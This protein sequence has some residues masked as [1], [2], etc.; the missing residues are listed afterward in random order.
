M[1]RP[2]LH[3]GLFSRSG[4]ALLLLASACSD[5][6]DRKVP[7]AQPLAACAP[8]SGCAGCSS[9]RE[10]CLCAGQSESHCEQS[11]GPSGAGASGGAAGSAGTSMAGS[12]GAG[13]AGASSGGANGG[14]PNGGGCSEWWPTPECSGGRSGGAAGSASGAGGQGGGSAGVVGAG[15]TAGSSNGG[16]GPTTSCGGIACQSSLPVGNVSL[17]AC[18]SNLGS[19]GFD[20][21]P[22]RRELP[23]DGCVALNQPGQSDPSCPTTPISG[24]DVTLPGCCKPN[25]TCGTNFTALAP[26]GCVDTNPFTG[27]PAS[28]CRPGGETD[29]G[30]G[31]AGTG[32]FGGQSGGRGGAGASGGQSGQEGGVTERCCGGVG[33]CVEAMSLAP[34]L[35]SSLGK[36]ICSGPTKRCVPEQLLS[37]GLLPTCRSVADA[38]GR[39]APICIPSVAAV[40]DELP[41]STCDTS[42]LCAPC[43]EP[44]TGSLTGICNFPGDS[45][46]EPPR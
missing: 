14:G 16:H 20:A 1:G 34:S 35:E 30:G 10:L 8:E 42:S 41:R 44:G 38:E 37:G 39:C 15:A 22:L 13:V 32:G 43:Y 24:A 9:C 12:S 4:L 26:F 5:S 11:C 45:P 2:S 21:G 3:S 7:R 31:V 40:A 36:D 46:T 6:S 23:I 33:A 18:C 25:G 28:T 17:V 19:C 27:R 29:G